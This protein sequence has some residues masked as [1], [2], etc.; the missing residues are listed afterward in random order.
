MNRFVKLYQS[1]LGK[2]VIAAITGLI[3]FGFLIGHV[4]GNLKVFSAPDVAGVPSIDI[5][6]HHLRVVGEPMVPKYGVLWGARIVL[7]VSVVMHIV[8]VIQL[9]MDS[10]EAR[11]TGYVKTKRRMASFSAMYMM[12]SGLLI[13]FFVVFHILHFTAGLLKFGTFEHGRVYDNLYASF[14]SNYWYIPAFYIVTMVTIGFHLN[15]GVWS[16]F[17]TLGIDN[18][19]RNKL[20]RI[21]ATVATV[22]I[23][24]GF[25]AVPLAFL[26]GLM[27]EGAEYAS[28]ALSH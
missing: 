5:Y 7:L 6:A 24:A 12:F 13:A 3:L 10:A 15:H 18:P 17:Q 27:P 26:S 14:S 2:K 25:I 16:L 4:V 20:L 9:A 8:V 11:P 22:L 1:N 23:I 21:G 19:D 28:D